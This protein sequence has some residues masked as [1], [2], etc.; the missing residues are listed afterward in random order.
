MKNHF[1]KVCRRRR[2][3]SNFAGTDDESSFSE[4]ETEMSEEEYSEYDENQDREEEHSEGRLFATRAQDFRSRP[5]R[6]TRR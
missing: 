2:S 6:G 3:R 4:A 5:K 1:A